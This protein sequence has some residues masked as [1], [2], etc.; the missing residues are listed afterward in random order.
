MPIDAD[1]IRKL[2]APH[3]CSVGGI[4]TALRSIQATCQSV[5]EDADPIIADLFN[6]S[7]AEVRGIV[8]FY[9]DFSREPK[10]GPIV[11]VCA[12]EACQAA[13]GRSVMRDV[14]TFY[15]RNAKN[16]GAQENIVIE[17]V[18][19]L[20]LCSAAPAAMVGGRLVGR[21]NLARIEDALARTKSTAVS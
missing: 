4:I 14:E 2:A 7:R 20:G 1:L 19:C 6:L 3:V 21:A 9:A 13:G 11:R 17:P 5:P 18:Y 12:A 10:E 16:G 8:S 15:R